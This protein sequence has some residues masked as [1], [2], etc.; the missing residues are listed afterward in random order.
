LEQKIAELKDKGGMSFSNQE[1][2]ENLDDLFGSVCL[3]KLFRFFSSEPDHFYQVLKNKLKQKKKEIS[4]IKLKE[5]DSF[6]EQTG[7]TNPIL[8]NYLGKKKHKKT[9]FLFFLKNRNE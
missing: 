9:F 7:N 2:L 6:D 4:N 1:D 5:L 3:D 8:L